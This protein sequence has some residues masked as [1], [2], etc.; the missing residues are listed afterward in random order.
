M[1]MQSVAVKF[2]YG[3][4]DKEPLYQLGEKLE[5]ALDEAGAGDYDGYET[6]M[7]D[8]EGYF[9]MVGPDAKEIWDAIEPVVSK[10]KLLR[11]AEVE[12]RLGDADDDDT[13]VETFRVS[14]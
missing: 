11:G 10:A 1:A 7:D 2:K 14:R 12:L 3:S 13:E 9:L 8:S 5:E 4:A 6:S